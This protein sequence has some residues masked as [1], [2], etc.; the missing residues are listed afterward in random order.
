MAEI[1]DASKLLA[2][3][4]MLQFSKDLTDDTIIQMYVEQTNFVREKPFKQ[5]VE[6]FTDNDIVPYIP[7]DDCVILF[8]APNGAMLQIVGYDWFWWRKPFRKK[9]F[10]RI[11]QYHLFDKALPTKKEKQTTEPET[12]HTMY[13][14]CKL[15]DKS[16]IFYDKCTGT[17]KQLVAFVN[18]KYAEIQL[19]TQFE[20]IPVFAIDPQDDNNVV[21]SEFDELVEKGAFVL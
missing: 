5:M 4:H 15:P 19:K 11:E 18:T 6:F 2:Q 16:I 10:G 20:A 9:E 8:I 13:V 14:A 7:D 1:I 3:S 17:H 21:Y 12:L